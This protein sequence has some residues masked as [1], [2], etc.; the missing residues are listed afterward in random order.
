M[1]YT[2]LKRLWKFDVYTCMMVIMP[3]IASYMQ[4]LYNEEFM[5]D[6]LG[7]SFVI[8]LIINQ[9]IQFLSN[10]VLYNLSNL[11]A[12]K[13]KLELE[14]SYNSCNIEIPGTNK[15]EY[16]LFL[17]EYNNVMDY[18]KIFPIF[19]STMISIIISLVRINNFNINLILVVLIILCSYILNII[20]DDA[21]YRHRKPKPLEIL[22][23]SNPYYN[24]NKLSL[25]AIPNYKYNY[26]KTIKKLTQ[27]K[28]Q[29]LIISVLNTIFV[30][31]VMAFSVDDA[32]NK[33][34]IL[35]FM[36]VSWM[37]AMLSDNI[38]SFKMF[39]YI[40]TY[41][42]ILDGFNK[43][44]RKYDGNEIVNINKTNLK[45]ILSN[46]NFNYKLD[47]FKE[48][49]E[50]TENV[51]KNLSY[52]FERNIYY[53]ESPNGIGKSTLFRSLVQQIN[54]G[55]AMLD[56]INL[57]DLSLMQLYQLI[58]YVRQS[59]DFMPKFDK[60]TITHFISKNMETANDFDVLKFLN[61]SSNEMS[62]GE[63]QR[64]NIFLALTS[65]CV[66]LLFDETFSEISSIPTDE[67]PDGLRLYI[68]SKLSHW[69]KIFKKIIIIVG[70]GIE[71]QGAI[72]IKL[73]N[74][75]ITTIV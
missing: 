39:M 1:P 68:S 55:S 3:F 57:H 62:G 20:T 22:H 40:E 23:L 13:M 12:H 28:Y 5:K 64:L 31:I 66:V 48:D 29:T 67:Y 71:I 49:V 18:I 37:I 50:E 54:S 10:L 41:Y 44:N 7:S 14:L 24:Y 15:D 47:I 11:K 60:D 17:K 59:S 2:I 43:F 53:L 25:G 46:I 52:I 65:P 32:Y 45:L 69:N 51:I 42:K 61:K 4:I 58:F 38:K 36:N 72:K 26:N 35:N 16:E 21:L 8:A 75:D 34:N 73:I 63:K 6:V 9:F 30:L 74:D 70:H 33:K 27:H 56:N 19:W